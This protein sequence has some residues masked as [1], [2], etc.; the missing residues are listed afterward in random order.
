MVKKNGVIEEKSQ[1]GFLHAYYTMSDGKN[2]QDIHTVCDRISG[3]MKE[4][5][6]KINWT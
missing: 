2:E 1:T 6:M 5:G 3:Y 4:Y